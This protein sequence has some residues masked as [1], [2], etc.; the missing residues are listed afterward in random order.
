MNN[1][2]RDRRW[3]LQGDPIIA[4]EPCALALEDTTRQ[5]CV[6]IA[7][8]IA[9]LDVSHLRIEWRQSPARSATFSRESPTKTRAAWSCEPVIR[10]NVT[11]KIF[12]RSVI[13]D[14]NNFHQAA[15]VGL[16]CAD[17]HGRRGANND[18]LPARTDPT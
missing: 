5:R 8:G 11:V 6:Y 10:I 13:A 17:P 16:K 14:I 2:A 9:W 18:R 15:G 7:P 3:A 4:S 12:T 1:R